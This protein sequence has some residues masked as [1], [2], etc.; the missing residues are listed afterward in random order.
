MLQHILPNIPE[1]KIYTETFFGGGAVFFAKEKAE[2]EIINDTNAMDRSLKG[3]S[4]AASSFKTS[5]TSCERSTRMPTLFNNAA[6][7]K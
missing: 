6:N 1:H 3:S 4:I 5:Y 7:T 2:S